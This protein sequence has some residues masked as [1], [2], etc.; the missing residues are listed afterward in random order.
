MPTLL[1][2]FAKAENAALREVMR[3]DR[4]VAGMTVSQVT[5][6][7]SAENGGR[8]E[9]RTSRLCDGCGCILRQDHR[10]NWGRNVCCSSACLDDVKRFAR[11]TRSTKL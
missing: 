10:W 7:V 2:Q 9:R 5:K 1:E 8:I 3:D 4:G 6:G 11:W